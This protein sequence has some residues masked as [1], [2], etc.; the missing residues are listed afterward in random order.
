MPSNDSV[1]LDFRLALRPTDI[2][3]RYRVSVHK[4]LRWIATSE[5]RAIN[6]AT[7]IAR[8]PRWIVTPE[9]LAEFERRRAAQLAPAPRRRRRKKR[10]D[11]IE[12][13]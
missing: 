12:F 4:I 1:P 3:R 10:A 7:D 2:A 11:V 6:V 8:R 5:L 13:F 9:A